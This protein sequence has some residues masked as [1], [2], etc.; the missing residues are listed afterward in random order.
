VG[1]SPVKLLLDTHI[2]L[3][4]VTDPSR[5]TIRVA[6]A[7]ADIENE[8]WL[9]SISVWELTVLHRKRRL[10]MPS[11]VPAWVA[12]SMEDLKLIE[13]PLT[14]E[15]ALAVGSISFSHADPADH[16]LAAT[17][18]VFDLTLVTADEHLLHLPGIHVLPNR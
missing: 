2:W 13:A 8:L 6:K 17:A 12:T 10:K 7:L 15:V 3:W 14:V 16:L 4:S 11:D 18:K 1:R 9:S 5:L